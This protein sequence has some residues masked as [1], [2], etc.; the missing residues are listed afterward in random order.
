MFQEDRYTRQRRLDEVGEHGQAR[1]EA[2]TGV[3]R[4]HEGALLE[5]QYLHRAGFGR[6]NILAYGEPKPFRHSEFFRHPIARMAG[7]GAWRALG[8]IR[9]ELGIDD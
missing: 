4:G 3:V 5:A 7:A 8:K 1:L 9:R 2:A 6:V